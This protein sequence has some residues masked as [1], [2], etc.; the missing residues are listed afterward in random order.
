MAT[1]LIT[2]SFQA[3]IRLQSHT[4]AISLKSAKPICLSLRQHHRTAAAK[5]S[6][7]TTSIRFAG[8]SSLRFVKFRPFASTGETETTETQEEIQEPQIE[9][10]RVALFFEHSKEIV[11]FCSCSKLIFNGK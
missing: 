10:Q 11:F 9:V 3:P 1:V 5:L 4:A 6:S 2:A 8:V 7:R